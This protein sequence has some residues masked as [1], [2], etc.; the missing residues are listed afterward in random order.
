[1]TSKMSTRRVAACC[2]IALP[3]I[4]L[5][6]VSQPLGFVGAMP[7]VALPLLGLLSRSSSTVVVLAVLG[8][9]TTVAGFFLS[10]SAAPLLL[11]LSNRTMTIVLI[12]VVSGMAIRHLILGDRL[13]ETLTREA[14]HDPLT[15]LYNRRYVFD[16]VE[17]ELKRFRR[18]GDCFSLIL[19]DVDYFKRVN[20]SLGHCAGDAALR[21]IADTCVRSVRETDV[22]GRFGGE[23][24][25]VVLPNTGAEEARL[26]AE[27]IRRAVRRHKFTW[28]NRVVDIT[29]SLGVAEVSLE[30]ASFNKLIKTADEALYAAKRAGRDRVVVAGAADAGLYKRLAA[31]KSDS[32][33]AQTA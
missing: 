19:I 32:A 25:I 7:C 13:R 18:Y 29:M 5:L 22:V 14:S 28:Q 20:D 15:E 23:E 17:I 2:A 27:R 6:D 16:V 1:M 12:W 10:P 3:A 26:T 21:H 4:L 33:P 11:V 31:S 8:S 9:L 24:F 30:S